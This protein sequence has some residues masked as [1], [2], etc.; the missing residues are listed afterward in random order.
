MQQLTP[1]IDKVASPYLSGF[2]KKH[3]YQDVL[4]NFVEKNV[5][6]L[7]RGW[8]IRLIPWSYHRLQVG[9]GGVCRC[10]RVS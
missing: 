9:F 1:F 2:R 7:L 5:K 4:L 6:W 8:G 10:I 3:S